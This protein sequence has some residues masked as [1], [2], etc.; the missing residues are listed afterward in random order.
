MKNTLY[1][2][3]EEGYPETFRGFYS[4]E[5]KIEQVKGYSWHN[6]FESLL[7][8]ENLIITLSITNFLRDYQV[9]NEQ[10][11]PVSL[12]GFYYALYDYY[13]HVWTVE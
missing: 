11:Y 2:D 6:T 8:N 7:E 10:K 4:N 9:E 12:Q 5:T 1:I 3:Y 13:H